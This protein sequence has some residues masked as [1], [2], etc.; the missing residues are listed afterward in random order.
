MKNFTPLIFLTSLILIC[1]KLHA[2]TCP[3]LPGGPHY[4]SFTASEREHYYPG[5]VPAGSPV[6]SEG[7]KTVILYEFGSTTIAEAQKSTV[8]LYPTLDGSQYGS[9]QVI[10]VQFNFNA[11]TSLK[12]FNGTDNTAPLLDEVNTG[13]FA[14][15]QGTQF[16]HNGPLTIEFYGDAAGPSTAN[17]LRLTTGDTQVPSCNPDRPTALVW[18]DFITADSYTIIDDMQ[19][20]GVG[21]LQG[22]AILPACLAYFDAAKNFVGVEE[23][24][25][26]DSPK[27]ASSPGYAWYP[28]EV[29]FTLNSATSYDIDDNGFDAATDN[30]KIARILYLIKLSLSLPPD[31]NDAI[32]RAIWDTQENPIN[33]AFDGGSYAAQAQSNITSVPNPIEPTF[34]V[35]LV[36]PTPAQQPI[37]TSMTVRI[38]FS[39][40]SPEGGQ[41][42]QVELQIPAGLN[43]TLISGGSL[44]GTTLTFTAPEVFL[45]VSS[46]IP[47]KYSLQ[48][49]Y[50][51]P[52]YYNINNLQVYNPCDN[53]VQRFLHIGQNNHPEPFRSLELQFYNLATPVRLSNFD[54]TAVAQE[55]QL[56]WGTTEEVGFSHFEVLR[57]NDLNQWESIGNVASNEAGKYFFTD[58][59]LKA[60]KTTYYRLKM[61][62]L[63]GTFEYSTI[64]SINV[65]NGGKLFSVYPN[66]AS[67]MLYLNYADLKQLQSLT[68]YDERG[69][70]HLSRS[71]S[72]LLHGIK[73][74]NLPQGMHFVQVKTKDGEVHSDK[75]LIRN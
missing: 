23:S 61:V 18:K 48:A 9:I 41:T 8:T 53:T 7:H 56:N 24:W 10:Y 64:R 57:S 46:S 17:V 33:H 32:Q 45:D 3:N 59:G 22:D 34:D 47:G 21:F 13:N 29:T 20:G 58:A 63:D 72:D 4:S 49:I 70:T 44:S 12:F 5:N 67:E 65:E 71:G 39:W 1:S 69:N 26:L 54:V 31:Q 55:A 68:I 35:E 74:A 36:S 75:L 30:L 14:A 19:R 42:N 60:G 27:S 73:I 50:D 25:C 43:V 38:P 52:L 37:N 2:Q 66:P 28:G 16:I 15:K 51:N 40:A 6:G 62:D 11:G